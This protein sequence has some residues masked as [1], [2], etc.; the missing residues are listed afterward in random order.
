[1]DECVGNDGDM[2]RLKYAEKNLYEC[3]LGNQNIPQ[4]DL[5]MKPDLGDKGPATYRQSLLKKK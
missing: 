4:A 5:E 2:A 3:Y 1:M